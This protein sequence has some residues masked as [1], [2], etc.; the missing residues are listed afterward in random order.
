MLVLSAN[1]Y[2]LLGISPCIE[3]KNYEMTNVSAW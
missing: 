3:E 1:Y 2:M